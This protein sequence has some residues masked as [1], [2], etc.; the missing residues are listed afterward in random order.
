MNNWINFKN[1]YNLKLQFLILKPSSKIEGQSFSAVFL[2]LFMSLI[3]FLF[4]ANYL[5]LGCLLSGPKQSKK[6]IWAYEN[7]LQFLWLS[8]GHLHFC[9]FA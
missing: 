2:G 4:W 7:C 1:F 8:H 9:S 3:G 5:G 6:P